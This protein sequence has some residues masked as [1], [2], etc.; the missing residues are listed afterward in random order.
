MKD[1]WNV[2]RLR[3][4]KTCLPVYVSTYLL[5]HSCAPHFEQERFFP[6]LVGDQIEVAD[7]M[8]AAVGLD[9]LNPLADAG[10]V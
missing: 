6:R 8:L 1:E 10:F 3:N 7:A 5:D 4:D 2:L 9:G